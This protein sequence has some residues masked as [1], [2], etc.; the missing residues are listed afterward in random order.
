[1]YQINMFCEETLWLKQGVVEKQGD[2]AQVLAAYEAY[3]L[4]KS[5]QANHEGQAKY[6]EAPVRI[7]SVEILNELP[8]SR[9]DDLKLKIQTESISDD[10]PFHIMV[11]L[12]Y[13]ADFGVYATGTHLAGKPPIRGHQRQ[14]IVTYPKIALLGGYYWFHVRTMDD[15]GI[16]IY[17]EK[18]LIDPE[19]EVRRD[20]KER[21]YCYLENHW[22][23]K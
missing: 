2:T 23:I 16:I 18:I 17:H 11:S 20:S 8:I 21:G 4:R 7:T 9:G 15:Q 19:L 1:M 10:L 5:E 13:G 22:E 6:A 14:I 3:Q 12:K